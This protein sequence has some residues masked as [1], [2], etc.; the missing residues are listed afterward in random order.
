[1]TAIEQAQRYLDSGAA[2]GA[3]L[4]D[5]IVLPL[6]QSGG[7]AFLTLPPTDHFKTNI[8][9]LAGFFEL[10]IRTRRVDETVMI[11]CEVA[12]IPAR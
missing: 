10:D 6:T 7:G 2:A 3:H 5:Q 4:A 9:V 1:M 8:E 11:E 12:G